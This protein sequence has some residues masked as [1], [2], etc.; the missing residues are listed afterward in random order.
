MAK[1]ATK[2]ASKTAVTPA[3]AAKRGSGKTTF[4]LTTDG[5]TIDRMIAV[6]GKT[7]ETF[8]QQIAT[9][10]AACIMHAIEHSGIEKCNALL[11]ALSAADA[12]GKTPW[13]T[14]ALR[15]WYIA[16]GPVKVIEVPTENGKTKKELAFDAGKRAKLKKIMD[17]DQKRFASGLQAKPFWVLKPEKEFE[18][19]DFDKEL[20]K[21]F[22]KADRLGKNTKLTDDQKALIKFGSM[23]K[24]RAAFEG[25]SAT[26]H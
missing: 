21:L 4:S 18:G 24:V 10:A 5:A 19:F 1:K 25:G 13:R 2:I 23:A 7:S 26:V 14:N 3:P 11:K 12:S 16:E 9:C 8:K 15:D 20:G 17:A 6:I 22:A